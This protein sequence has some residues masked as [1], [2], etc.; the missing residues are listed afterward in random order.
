VIAGDCAGIRDAEEGRT[1]RPRNEIAAA[2][3]GTARSDGDGERE[4]VVLYGLK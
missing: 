3:G 1:N 2:G 4:A